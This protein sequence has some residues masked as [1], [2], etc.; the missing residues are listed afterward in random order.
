MLAIQIYM[1]ASNY[2][3]LDVTSP[4]RNRDRTKSD[5]KNVKPSNP[6]EL[7]RAPMTHRG[8][9]SPIKKE[10]GLSK[11]TLL[12]TDDQKTGLGPARGGRLL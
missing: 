2:R 10:N 9:V 11:P 12:H 4:M 8:G 3:Q 7:E 6:P 1:K 5:K